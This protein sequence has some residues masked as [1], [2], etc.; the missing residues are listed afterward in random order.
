[1]KIR[2]VKSERNIPEHSHSYYV[3]ALAEAISPNYLI[4]LKNIIY[5]NVWKVH[6][7]EI[8]VLAIAVEN[9]TE[10]KAR[11]GR[12]HFHELDLLSIKLKWANDLTN[13]YDL[14]LKKKPGEQNE[15]TKIINQFKLQN[16]QFDLYE[17]KTNYE[18]S[19]LEKA[20]RQLSLARTKISHPGKSYL[21]T[22]HYGLEPLEKIATELAYRF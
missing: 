22:P 6:L 7:G 15:L 21:Y 3:Q 16:C 2:R 12:L 14:G 18:L 11:N 4:V 19:S 10:V 13:S 20:I 17:V 1:M 5:R 8:D 9:L